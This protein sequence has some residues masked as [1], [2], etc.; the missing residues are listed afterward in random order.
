MSRVLSLCTLS[1]F[2][3]FLTQASIA[4]T[5]TV[6]KTADTN[7]GSCDSDCSLREAIA[8]A[9][10]SPQDDLIVFGSMFDFSQ[11][12]V[13]SGT[14]IV[15]G[16]GT[17]TVTGPGAG[18]L[19]IDGN[20]A[21]RIFRTAAGVV[22]TING[23][24]FIRGNGVSSSTSNSGGA[25]L[26]DVGSLTLVNC[27]FENNTTSSS[28]GAVRNSGTNSVMNIVDCLFLNNASTGSSAG[29]VQNFSTSTMTI[30]GSTF[31]GNRSGGGTVGGGAIQ[32]NGMLRISNSTFTGNI[33]QATGGGGGINSNGSL[34]LMTNVTMTGNVSGN[35]AGA[36]HR[37]TTNVNGFLRNSI[38]AGNNGA[39]AAPDVSNSAGGL[40]SQGNNLIGNV[41]TSTG[42]VASD[43][44]NVPAL[45][46]P[47]GNYG[48]PTMTHALLSGSPALNAGQNCVLDLSCSAN[49]PP[50]AITTDQRGAARPANTTVDIG[51]FESNS[52]FV[53]VLP[54][55]QT[56]VAYSAT[57]TPDAGGFSYTVTNGNLPPG[58]M[59]TSS[60]A[61][62]G[63]KDVVPD[64]SA[65]N[66]TGTPSQAG[67]YNFAITISGGTNSA[68]INY[69]ITVGGV[70][71]SAVVSGQVVSPSGPVKYALVVLDNPAG[72]DY[73]ART[74]QFGYFR[75][76][77][78]A[79]G[80]TYTAT[81]RAR[82]HTFS[83]QMITV[84]ADVSNL[85]FT[86]TTT[87]FQ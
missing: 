25:I 12:I 54:G 68:V 82:A 30:T 1:F 34:L 46:S 37:S 16:A 59:L 18:K 8:A 38:I 39:A 9:N 53:A 14:E 17:L 79:T 28:A 43:I 31:I 48:G 45:V 61:E 74:N 26:N 15:I 19:T 81:V 3:F 35:N 40:Q 44:T 7:D 56:G 65:V 24:R 22:A 49:N 47:L 84:N 27:I 72:T 83:P 2:L 77:D 60:L 6:N 78:V 41:G 67:V 62:S 20:M 11:T 87:D 80:V 64:G 85:N 76:E 69:R 73:S 23:I 75:I 4:A 36:L 32:G 63:A 70:A 86:A 29:A 5:F 10:A 33:N 42:W 66:I 71:V 13:L 55:G 51:A 52:G 50:A 57:I 21:S 58:L